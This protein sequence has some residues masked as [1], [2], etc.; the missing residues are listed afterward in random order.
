MSGFNLSEWSIRNRSIVIYL[1]IVIVVAGVLSFLHLGRAEDP[2]FTIRTMVVQAQWPGATLDETLLQVTERL[3]RTLQEV[4]NLDALR[5]YTNAGRTVIF[6][7][8]LGSAHGRE[9]DDAWYD[10]RKKIGDMRQTLPQGV[11]GPFFNDEFGDTYGTIYGFT[12]DGFTFREL[13]DYV[14]NIRSEL[15]K[16]PDV[17]KIDV[18][19]AAGRSH[20][21]RFFEREAGEPW[22]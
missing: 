13:R 19:G 3:E 20:L 10:V 11:V 8:L 21:R 6:V 14:E 17:S 12:A 15:L 7:E 18:L 9:V 4:P 1:M 22:H 16:I 5:S 2:V